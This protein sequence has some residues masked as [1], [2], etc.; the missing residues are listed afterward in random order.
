MHETIL[1]E[2]ARRS[3]Y[4][5]QSIFSINVAYIQ[6]FSCYAVFMRHQS[7]SSTFSREA[8][9]RLGARIRRARK[10]RHITLVQLEARCGVHRS[11]LARL[12]A[13][14]LG[15]S[16]AVLAAVLEALGRLSEI[17]LLL[18]NP[19]PVSGPVASVPRLDADF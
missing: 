14:D 19:E 8:F 16:F 4:R 1:P 5:H 10:A 11:T 12:E 13:G 6:S 9:A 18:A 2:M 15:V 7:F 17:E 3:P